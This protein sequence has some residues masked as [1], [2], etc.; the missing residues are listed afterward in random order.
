VSEFSSPMLPYW[1]LLPGTAVVLIVLG[2]QFTRLQ[3]IAAKFVFLACALRFVMTAFHKFTFASSPAGVSWMAVASLAMVGIGL[4]FLDKGRF[5]SL[6]FVP[7]ALILLLMLVSA[8][9]N[10]APGE[11]IEPILRFAFFTVICVGFAQAIE[12]GGNKF[13]QRFLW[14]FLPPLAFQAISI[15]LGISKVSEADGSASYVGGYAHESGLSMILATCFVVASFTRLRRLTKSLLL[16]ASLAGIWV[17]NYRTAIIGIAPVAIMQFVTGIPQAFKRRQRSFVLGFMMAIAV[18]AAVGTVS[19]AGERFADVGI[20]LTEGTNLIKPPESLSPDE[21]GLLTGR[22]YLWNS[23]YYAYQQGTATQHIVG[24]GPDS[25]TYVFGRYAHN[26]LVSYLFELGLLGVAA[27]LLLWTSMLALALKLPR[28]IRGRI[29]AAH[30]S[31]FL[32]NMATMPHWQIEGNILYAFI[33][34]YTLAAERSRAKWRRRQAILRRVEV[35][36]EPPRRPAAMPGT[37][38]IASRLGR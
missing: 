3:G 31:F 32:L 28:G 20:I 6:R 9:L 11:A 13:L 5:L 35:P 16:V 4:V 7:V 25:W 24:F 30:A 23:Y 33:C 18:I 21:R 27:I 12:A 1:A 22:V 19:F 14:V 15:V 17:A 38:R 10:N 36:D 8:L 29:V 2:Y 37:A 26:T 34:G